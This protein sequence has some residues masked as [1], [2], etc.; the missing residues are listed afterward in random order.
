MPKGSGM[1]IFLDASKVSNN[2]VT[3]RMHPHAVITGRVLDQYGDPV[4][5]AIAHVEDKYSRAE[6]GTFYQIG[7]SAFTD[8]LG[9]FRLFNVPPGKH[10]LAFEY[11][12]V[13]EETATPVTRPRR[14]KWPSLQG[15]VLYPN[16][17]DTEHAQAVETEEGG[18]IELK[19]VRMKI[20]APLRVS[21][22]VKTSDLAGVNVT[23]ERQDPIALTFRANTQMLGLDEAGRFN[24]DT[25][26]GK[27]RL[28]AS[29]RK[30]GMTSK[31]LTLDVGVDDVTGI[32]LD[33]SLSYELSGRFVW[34]G[35]D[36]RNLSKVSLNVN[37]MPVQ[38]GEGGIFEAQAGAEKAL[39]GLRDL[40][41]GIY[42]RAVYLGGNKVSGNMLDLSPGKN[43]MTF[44]L[45]SPG[46]Q[47][48]IR[49]EGAM[50]LKNPSYVVL[51]PEE[52]PPPPP[53]LTIRAQRPTGADGAYV[54]SSIP[55]GRYRVFVLNA[56]NWPM[57]FDTESLLSKYR[58]KAPL[59]DLKDGEHKTLTVPARNLGQD[60]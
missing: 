27:Y 20:A 9:R 50:G 22:K 57:L 32:E 26:P 47:V 59:I 5:H 14:F 12:S 28:T 51:L 11:D 40:P 54:I 46:A 18:L 3:V 33:P 39:Y 21:G 45:G 30:T 42:L 8:D 55:P 7:A 60:N 53:D 1:G 24:A 16:A 6:M 29:N 25:L 13:R 38:I 52:G 49:V 15:F 34:S 23:F 10:Y 56:S 43:E 41:E 31:P 35:P 2:V 19:D 36:T 44:L 58:D 37:G 48:A 17:A 4:R